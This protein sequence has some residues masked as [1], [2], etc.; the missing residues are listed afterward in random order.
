MPDAR[1]NDV[2]S[3]PRTVLVTGATGF[4]GHHLVRRLAARPDTR[5]VALVRPTSDRSRLSGLGID[6]VQG[7][8]GRPET[9]ERVCQGVDEVYH[10]ACA[11]QGTFAKGRIPEE[12]FQR[13]NVRGT[14]ALA[15]AAL[16]AGVR[17]FVHVSSTAA[18]GPPRSHGPMD[19]TTPCHPTTPYGRSKRDA[20]LLLLDMHRSRGLPVVILRPCLV[21]GKGKKN[22]ELFKMFVLVRWGAFP[23][24]RG[25]TSPRKPL[26]HVEDLITA[27]ELAAARGVPGEIYLVTSGVSYRLRDVVEVTA[28]LLGVRR[29]H[30]ELPMGPLRLVAGLAE[31]IGDR[32]GVVPPLT[33][34]RL[35]LFTADRELVIDKARRDLGYEPEHTDLHELLGDVYEE[36]AGSPAL[37]GPV[38]WVRRRKE[39]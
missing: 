9:L 19:E 13:V 18:M 4:V 26:V 12:E 23:L 3:G 25:H 32:L 28:G 37:R 29:S 15:Q 24:L 2:A 21:A 30:V 11:I 34:E 35:D 27:C 20:E 22:S 6:F 5:V 10:T 17:R 8:L 33:K 36:F 31:A 16:S 14:E 1:P 7:D 39:R 38:H